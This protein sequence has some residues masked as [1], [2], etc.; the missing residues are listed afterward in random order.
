LQLIIFSS[1][2]LFTLFVTY[3]FI[4]AP[5][6]TL[7]VSVAG[8]GVGWSRVAMLLGN[9][10]LYYYPWL[11]SWTIPDSCLDSGSSEIN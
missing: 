2:H 10:L 4:L 7:Q 9:Y 6:L 11:L 3:T 8:L 5:R 1:Q